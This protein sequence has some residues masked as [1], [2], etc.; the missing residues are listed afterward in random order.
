MDIY[1]PRYWSHCSRGCRWMKKQN[2]CKKKWSEVLSGKCRNVLPGWHKNRNVNQSCRKAC[3][4]CCKDHSFP[5]SLYQLKHSTNSIVLYYFISL[6][7]YLAIPPNVW[8]NWSQYTA[9][10]T[11]C[12]L[13][14]KI[15]TRA[16]KRSGCTGKHLE[17]QKCNQQPCHQGNVLS[18]YY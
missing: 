6:Y 4:V 1:P 7:Q 3:N 13:G 10:S 8:A 16:C 12:G 9:C 2:N 15:R 14:V 17:T 5:L 18:H 11:T